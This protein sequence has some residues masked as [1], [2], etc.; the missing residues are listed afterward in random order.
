MYRASTVK[1]SGGQSLGLLQ[2]GE[3]AVEVIDH[4][5]DR[6]DAQERTAARMSSGGG[7]TAARAH[8][9]TRHGAEMLEQY[10]PQA[11]QGKRSVAPAA[12]A[13]P[14]DQRE[15]LLVAFARLLGEL[16]R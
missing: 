13:S 12:R 3:R 10:A 1:P 4:P 14:L 5:L 7:G 11:G 8:A 16:G 2:V 15:R 9:T 6:R